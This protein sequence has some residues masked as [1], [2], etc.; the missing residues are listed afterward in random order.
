MDQL[1][2]IRAFARVVEAGSFTKAADTLGMPNAT[3]T[4][5]VQALEAHLRIKLLQ[6]TTRRVSV[7]P[8][9]GQ[10]YEKTQ[11]LLKELDDVDASFS[12]AQSRPRGHLRVDLGSSTASLVL[13][14]ALPAFLARYPDIR[15]DLGVS[16]KH[17]NLIGDNVDCVIRGGELTDLSLIGRQ[18]GSTSWVTCATPAY[19]RDHGTPRHPAELEQGHV[20]VHYLSTRT[21]RGMPLNFAK[22]GE[23]LEILGERS[24]GVNESNAHV[25]AGL[26][27]LGVMQTF[28][29]AAAPHIASGALVPI[30]DDWQPARYPFY[31]VYPSKRYVSSRLRVFIDWTADL[32][33]ALE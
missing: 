8:E 4:K 20:V 27:G 12:A 16:D 21:G 25:A 15:I 14:P 31:V 7:T 17:V 23:R 2:A 26:A 32:F 33:A 3:L 5:A 10:Y 19:L 30:L 6:R 13:L 29:H 11:R 28:R 9:G 1:Q 22:Q 18:V 24:V